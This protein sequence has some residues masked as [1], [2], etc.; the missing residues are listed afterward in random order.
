[1]V[2]AL[3][4]RIQISV[5][6]AG[7]MPGVQFVGP[8][9]PNDG[10]GCSGCAEQSW[11]PFYTIAGYEDLYLMGS[12]EVGRKQLQILV[13]NDSAGPCCFSLPEWNGAD[14]YNYAAYYGQS[15]DQYLQ[16]YQANIL[17]TQANVGGDF[18]LVQDRVGTGHQISSFASDT[19]IATLDNVS[20]LLPPPSPPPAPVSP[21]GTI[22][23]AGSNGSLMTAAGA[24]TFGTTQPQPGQYEIFLNG[25]HVPGGGYAAKMEVDNSGKLY[26]YN[27]DGN[28]WW[29]W[30]N[31]WSQSA[32][33]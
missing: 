23:T 13:A 18:G 1:M 29:V 16:L 12:Y 5:Q 7:S 20:A 26:A 22:L 15:W 33:P 31:G 8:V 19:A 6:I 28:L 32:A 11:A 3:D 4:P 27:S 9:N 30:N 17:T 24:W 10:D 25:S 21:D 14:G 2:A